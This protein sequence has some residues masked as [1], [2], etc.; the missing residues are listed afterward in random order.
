METTLDPDVLCDRDDVEVR[1]ETRTVTRAE[2]GTARDL[3]SHVTVGI[4]TDAGDLLFVADG[5]RGW[6]L[7]AVPVGPDEKWA[8]AARHA[9]ASLTGVDADLEDAVRVRRVDFQLEDDPERRHT[10]Y[11][12]LVRTAPL[13]GR[14]VADDP[15]L[16]GEDVDDLV[17]LDRVPDDA[18]DGVATAVESVL[19]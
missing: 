6:T 7:P 5:A 2:F 19:E 16:A 8:D 12:V 9:V 1:T 4:V 17:W 15:T 10:T 14:P 3:E 18:T 13:S 11:D